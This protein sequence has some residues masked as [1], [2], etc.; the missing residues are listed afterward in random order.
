MDVPPSG[1][2]HKRIPQVLVLGKER[3]DFLKKSTC[4]LAFWRRKE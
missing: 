2:P 4:C 1:I 3:G